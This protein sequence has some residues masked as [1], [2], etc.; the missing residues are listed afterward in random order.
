MM[1]AAGGG[2]VSVGETV[3]LQQFARRGE[4]QPHPDLSKGTPLDF[5]LSFFLL[6]CLIPE[7]QRAPMG[8][9]SSLSFIHCLIRKLQYRLVLEV[10]FKT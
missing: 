1:R 8:S 5:F 9:F 2:R 10:I 3:L 6:H 4:H 7:L